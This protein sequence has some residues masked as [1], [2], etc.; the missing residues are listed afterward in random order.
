MAN[1]QKSAKGCKKIGRG[2]R[3]GNYA[4]YANSGRRETRKLKHLLHS[5]GAAFARAWAERHSQMARYN[6][7]L[8]SHVS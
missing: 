3:K 1:K 5:N 4:R 7:L 2:K 8:A 6:R